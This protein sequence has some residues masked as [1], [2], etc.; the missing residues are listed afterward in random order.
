M[1][2]QVRKT[3]N[4]EDIEQSISF[5]IPH[6]QLTFITYVDRLY[7]IDFNFTKDTKPKLG[8]LK[9]PKLEPVDRESYLEDLWD[10]SYQELSAYKDHFGHCNIPISYEGNPSL[11]AWA[12]SQK[13]AFKKDKLSQERYDKLNAL[14]FPSVPQKKVIEEV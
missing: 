5:T 10:K 2:S 13:M 1:I 8:V 14:E 6:M 3:L 11:G 12:F 7:E 9:I 4:N